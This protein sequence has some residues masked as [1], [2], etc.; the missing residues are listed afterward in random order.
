MQL[1]CALIKILGNMKS[2]RMP[3][4]TRTVSGL[5]IVEVRASCLREAPSGQPERT[6]EKHDEDTKMQFGGSVNHKNN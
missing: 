3:H 2:M 1:V 4:L 5:I 6:F